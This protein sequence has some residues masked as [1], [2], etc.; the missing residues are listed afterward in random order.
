VAP[1]R[2]RCWLMM[3]LLLLLQVVLAQGPAHSLA[4]GCNLAAAAAAP[5]CRLQRCMAAV[6]LCRPLEGPWVGCPAVPCTCPIPHHTP[7]AANQQGKK[8]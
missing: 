6:L 5:G 8:R 2:C 4:V 7:A 3:L 1:A